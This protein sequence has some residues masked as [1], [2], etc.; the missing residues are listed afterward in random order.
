[1]YIITNIKKTI[2]KLYKNSTIQIFTI[3]I[4]INITVELLSR[5]SIISLYEH[6]IENTLFFLFN[7]LIISTTLCFSH[8]F[9]H[10]KLFMTIIGGLWIILGIANYI[11]LSYRI[12]PFSAIDFS[13]MQWNL[14]FISMYVTIPILILI[15]ISIIIS[16]YLIYILF[17]K[18]K[19]T[20][21][22]FKQT[23]IQTTTLSLIVFCGYQLLLN[24]TF[25]EKITNMQDSYN[26]FGFVTCFAR[27]TIERGIDEPVN[28][29]NEEVLNVMSS[30]I[31]DS[32]NTQSPNVIVVQLE[33]F[34][35]PSLISNTSYSN[36]PI[37]NY[38]SLSNENTSGFLDVAVVGAGTANTEFEVLSQMN[39]D[40]FGTGEFPYE[41]ILQTNTCSS[42]AYDLKQLGY[43][44]F[45][46][47]N[48]TA[49]FYDRY[50]VYPNLGFDYFIP[51]EFMESTTTTPQG[52][53]KDE[54]LTTEIL[55]CL[56]KDSTSDFIF[57]V[58][59]QGHGSF[60]TEELEEKHISV[61]NSPF[62]EELENQLEYYVNQLY[63]MD[64][65][66]AD[67]Y[68]EIQNLEEPT[69]LVLYGDH[70]PSLDL[71]ASHLT[72]NNNYQTS[73]VICS[74]YEL[75]TKDENLETYQ[76]MSK[77]FSLAD[78][79][80]GLLSS[81][82]L[83]NKEN[84]NYQEQLELLQYDLLYGNYYALNE[85]LYEPTNMQ[86]G[87]ADFSLTITDDSN[88][89]IISSEDIN[90]YSY[91]YINNKQVDYIYENHSFIIEKDILT[92]NDS[93]TIK[94][95]SDDNIVLYSS[96]S[97]IY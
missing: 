93:I 54:N 91:L 82:H 43:T 75:E 1:M 6:M 73:Y 15:F 71:E 80:Y 40:Y 69:V 45:A 76:L 29:S 58:S 38:T 46:L 52:W 44:T 86:I 85:T 57:A 77:V 95:I 67:L 94:Q 33:S 72:T 8:Y 79:D 70:I 78:I 42:V 63:E 64:M 74:N 96:D 62:D 53:I 89:Y 10:K 2:K 21:V 47:H 17:K 22:H 68:N 11:V 12:T 20:E 41:T 87:L 36:N 65:F 7:T 60:P 30:L 88:K 81:L 90:E 37:P 26:Q 16:C 14:D 50:K 55:K 18:P 51:S 84:S 4:L 49:T 24:G 31:E 23:L 28:Y 59:V 39:I 9:N 19:K 92:K 27:S 83:L 56:N 34:F 61:T 48:N 5:S 35:D 13:I 97:I 25:E 3:G 32:S 66:V